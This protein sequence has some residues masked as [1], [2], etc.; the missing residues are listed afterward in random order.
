[1]NKYFE[2]VPLDGKETEEGTKSGR[3]EINWMGRRAE[4]SK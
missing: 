4:M 1:M 3:E 2:I